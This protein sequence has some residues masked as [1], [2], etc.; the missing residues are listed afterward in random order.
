[1]KAGEGQTGASTRRPAPDVVVEKIEGASVLINLTTNRM[2]EL[3]ETG[4]R[5]WELLAE[6]HQPDAI[7]AQL[8]REYDVDRPTVDR[9]VDDLLAR[10]E[11]EQLVVRE[12]T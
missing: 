5:L 6:G 9:E 4:T 10:L 12:P 2:F 11:A 7:K 1:M 8:L 3:N